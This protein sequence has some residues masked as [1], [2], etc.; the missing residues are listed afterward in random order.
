VDTS[1][2]RSDAIRYAVWGS[3]LWLVVDF[4]TAGGFRIAYYQKYAPVICLFY[5]IFPI[6]FSY[7][8]IGRNWRWKK[9]LAATL[10]EIFLV[11]GLFVRNPL[12]VSFPTLLIG[13]PLALC[14]YAPLTYFPLWIVRKQMG[15]HKKMEILLTVVV[16][17]VSLL[18]TF[19]QQRAW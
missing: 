10:V 13:I 17:V 4:G 8:A 19:G 5:I 2:S 15:Q 11:E 3:L 1:R 16:V 7:L 6:I 12:L 9:L 18:S 14:V